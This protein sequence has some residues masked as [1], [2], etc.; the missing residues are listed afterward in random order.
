MKEEEKK[1]E[2]VTRRSLSRA[3]TNLEITS[4]VNLNQEGVRGWRLQLL[5]LGRYFDR[6]L[7]DSY[8]G[9]LSGWK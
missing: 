2:K 6:Y 9:K 4:K 1:E 7:H 8:L 5:K 3:T